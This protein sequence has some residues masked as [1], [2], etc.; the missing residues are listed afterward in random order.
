MSKLKPVIMAVVAAAF[1]GT[2]ASAA[3]PI[4][5]PEVGPAEKAPDTVYFEK[6][7][8]DYTDVRLDDLDEP[9][10][11]K[12]SK[13]PNAEALRYFYVPAEGPVLVIRID[14][15]EDDEATLTYKR[16]T[17]VTETSWGG[18]GETEVRVLSKEERKELRFRFDFMKYWLIEGYAPDSWDNT[19]GPLWLL[20]AIDG[21]KY[22]AI[23]RTNPVRG[24]ARKLSL[25][26]L[27]FVELSEQ[28]VA[29]SNRP[30]MSRAPG[31]E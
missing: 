9:S 29:V 13:N 30:V 15:N 5:A 27:S 10:L 2:S 1:W 31:G 26:L 12:M 17:G 28:D 22:H 21:S 14:I 8:F 4:K 25:L 7:H 6:D 16:S 23:Q 18:V 20:E 24:E 11:W 19:P 3:R